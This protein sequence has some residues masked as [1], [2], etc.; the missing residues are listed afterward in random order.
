MASEKLAISLEDVQGLFTD[1]DGLRKL[2]EE[3]V[4]KIIEAEFEKH[5]GRKRY[6][7]GKGRATHRN[8]YKPRMLYTRVG[9]LHL[10]V[11]QARDGSF[12]PSIYEKYQRSEKA[13]FLTLVEIYR[14]GVATRKVQDITEELCGDRISKSTVSRYFSQL[15]G[16]LAR[17]RNRELDGEYP[18]LVVDA[19]V[20]L[21][22]R[23]DKSITSKAMLVAEGVRYSGHRE[24]LGVAIGD[25]ENEQTWKDF[26][27]DLKQRGLRGVKYVVSD[28]HVGLVTAARMCFQG[29]V[30]QRCQQ[31]FQRNAK[32]YVSRSK[33]TALAR[34]LHSVWEASGRDEAKRIA[35]D[36]ARENRHNERLN[37][38][39][40]TGL[41]DCLTVFSL[42]PEHRR[43]MRTN[44]SL[45]RMNAEIR[46]RTRP[47]RILPSEKGALRLLTSLWQD[48]HEKWISGRRYLDMTPLEEWNWYEQED[49]DEENEPIQAEAADGNHRKSGT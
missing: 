23:P 49:P 26:F 44:N 13:L 35:D 25:S 41:E 36:I 38:L 42:P 6:E 3:S 31:H 24:V 16:E 10:R 7:R 15:D 14:K 20:H 33:R 11:P 37:K 40:S 39:L 47:I 28:A 21:I 30:W 5:M 4:Q 48:I 22:R 12:S 2:V 19:Q 17:F 27:L 9:T 45:E 8:G 32:G 1:K 34:Q 43:R 18:Y 46:R 29:C